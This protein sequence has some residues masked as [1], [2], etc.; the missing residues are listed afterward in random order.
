MSNADPMNAQLLNPDET[1]TEWNFHS[2]PIENGNI[3]VASSSFSRLRSNTPFSRSQSSVNRA[4]NSRSRSF[5]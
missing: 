2:D 3:S 1:A 5:R 4:S